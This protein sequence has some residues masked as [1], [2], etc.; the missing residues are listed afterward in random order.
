MQV[1][2]Q[3]GAQIIMILKSAFVCHMIDGTHLTGVS[4]YCKLFGYFGLALQAQPGGISKRYKWTL[5]DIG[6]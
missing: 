1:I 3:G 2:E 5:Y 6:L 4:E